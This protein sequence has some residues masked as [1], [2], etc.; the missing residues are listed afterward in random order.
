LAARVPVRPCRERAGQKDDQNEEK[1]T[2]HDETPSLLKSAP[3]QFALQI[4]RWCS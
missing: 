2:V 1:N 4:G 3:R